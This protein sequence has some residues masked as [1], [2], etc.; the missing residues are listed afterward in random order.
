MGKRKYFI[1]FLLFF[2][3][4]A[5]GKQIKC[6][7]DK[8]ED[9]YICYFPDY[10]EFGD[11]LKKLN[12][13]GTEYFENEMITVYLQLVY[14]NTLKD[15]ALCLISI[16]SS[17][18]SLLVEMPAINIK[19]YGLY[20]INLPPFQ[21]G[22]YLISAICSW[23]YNEILVFPSSFQEVQG[24]LAGNIDDLKKIDGRKVDLKEVNDNFEIIFNFTV[25][26]LTYNTSKMVLYSYVHWKGSGENVLYWIYN[27]VNRSWDYVT[28]APPSPSWITVNAEIYNISRYISNNTIML[29]FNTSSSSAGAPNEVFSIDYLGIGLMNLTSQIVDNIRG[30]GEIHVHSIEDLSEEFARRI[31]FEGL[32]AGDKLTETV[33]FNHDYCI[34]NQTLVKEMLIRKCIEDICYNYTKYEYINCEFGCA[35]DRCNPSPFQN[36]L[37]LMIIIVAVSIITGVIYFL[38]R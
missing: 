34:D 9:T 16:F 26:A 7:Y 29:R 25:P 20:L 37:I 21:K 13:H 15:D 2:I 1:I 8:K 22:N 33:I 35:D 4:A 24:D 18:T 10:F 5:W 23:V 31:V 17:N 19:G 36:Y 11:L 6:Y 14:N 38:I 28:Y 30:G 12:I 3:S 27:F 32:K